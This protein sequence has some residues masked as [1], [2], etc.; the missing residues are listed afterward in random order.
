MITFNNTE[1]TSLA[2]FKTK[3]N[4]KQIKL[5]GNSTYGFYGIGD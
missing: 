1:I 5:K 3:F 2:D 4:G